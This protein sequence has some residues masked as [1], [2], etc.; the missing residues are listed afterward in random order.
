[1]TLR[2]AP[3]RIVSLAPGATEMLYA[4][5]L[6]RYMVGDTVYGDYPSP[7]RKVAKIG[8]VNTNIEK[9]VS[10]RPDLIVATDAN[11]G[12]AARLSQLHQPVFVIAPKSL[13]SIEQSLTLLGQ[14]TG[15]PRQAAAVAAQMEAKCRVAQAIAAHD[16]RHRPRVLV[17]IGLNPLWTAGSGTFIDDILQRAGGVNVAAGIHQYAPLSKEALL[18]NPPDLILASPGDAAAMRAD[19]VFRRLA[20]VREGRFFSIAPDLISR[21]GPRLADA[22]VQVAQALH[23]RVH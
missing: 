11:N 21:P 23:P 7:A 20:A 19:P 10:L 18:A 6:G 9:V 13:A 2:A 5:G 3:R 12:A 14:V 16:P 4:L 1:V 15:T 8:G 17:V 22:L